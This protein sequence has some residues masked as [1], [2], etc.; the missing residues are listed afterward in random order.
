[1]E[2]VIEIRDLF[3]AYGAGKKKSEAAG[4]QM[5]TFSRGMKQKVSFAQALINDPDLLSTGSL[6]GWEKHGRG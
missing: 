2:S 1:M 3:H 6:T 5:R 4:R